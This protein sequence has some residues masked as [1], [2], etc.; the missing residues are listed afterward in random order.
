MKKWICSL[1]LVPFIVGCC[2]TVTESDQLSTNRPIRIAEADGVV[3]YKVKDATTGGK[4][5]VYFTSDGKVV[6]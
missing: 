4:I 2:G 1:L 5:Y 3:L 6:Q